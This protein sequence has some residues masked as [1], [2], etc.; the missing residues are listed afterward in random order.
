[1]RVPPVVMRAISKAVLSIY[2]FLI[3]VED[4]VNWLRYCEFH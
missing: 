4:E 2:I 3:P 1:M